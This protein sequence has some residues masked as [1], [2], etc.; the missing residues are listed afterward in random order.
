MEKS[1]ASAISTRALASAGKREATKASN[2]ASLMPASAA[3]PG[4]VHELGAAVAGDLGLCEVALR[5]VGEG[6]EGEPVEDAL[7]VARAPEHRVDE[8][9]GEQRYPDRDR[10]P[11]DSPA[12]AATLGEYSEAVR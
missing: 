1:S 10:E 5:V 12:H 8:R 4:L 7:G 3:R 11:G 9:E 2:S 6:E